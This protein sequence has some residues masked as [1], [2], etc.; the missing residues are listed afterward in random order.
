MCE[1]EFLEKGLWRYVLRIT[2]ILIE[3]NTVVNKYIFLT[4][5]M[6]IFNLNIVNV[7]TNIT[8]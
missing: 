1:C 3:T 4:F 8:P 6:S 2:F 7:I 5:M